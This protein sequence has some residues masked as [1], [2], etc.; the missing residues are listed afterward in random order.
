MVSRPDN[1]GVADFGLKDESVVCFAGGDWWY[2]HPHTENHITKRLARQNRVLYVNSLTMGLPS[3][4]NPDFLLKIRRKLK[5]YLRWLRTLPD[6]MHVLTP[7]VLPFFG[8]KTVRALNLFLLVMQVRLAMWL[9]GMRKPVVWVCIPSAA[10]IASR[11]DAKVILYQVSD[12]YDANQDSALSRDI[13]R[14]MDT[15]LKTMAASTIYTGR[16]LFDESHVPNRVLVEQGVD[17][18]HFAQAAD[19]V[20]PDIA[21]IPSPIL[22]YMGA[23]DHVVDVPLVEE[24]VRRRPD[25]H[26]VFVGLKS[27]LVSISAPN[28]HFLGSKP[29]EK[30]P[31]YLCRFDVCVLPWSQDSQFVSYGSATKVREYLATGKPVVISPMYEY[32]NTPG[33]RVYRTADEFIRAVEDSLKCDTEA[34][35]RLRQSLVRNSTWDART[36]EVAALISG[37]LV[38][39]TV[40]QLA[41]TAGVAQ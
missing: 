8:S 23:I 1:N 25:W 27:N 36:R 4:S 35:R 12:K 34:D 6:G 11:L 14:Q 20:A 15:Q 7:A 16:R 29:Y 5:S 3:V 38:D 28:V 18:D 30:L 26:W 9:C 39:G 17:F 40:P 22:G 32:L 41:G 33:I 31:E 21:S 2:H 19:Q 10:D 24:V 13:I 37:L